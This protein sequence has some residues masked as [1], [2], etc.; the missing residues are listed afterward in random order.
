MYATI[1]GFF[2]VIGP[3]L[4]RKFKGPHFWEQ[5]ISQ[6]ETNESTDFETQF[7]SLPTVNVVS[8]PF[9][10]YSDND[11]KESP[12]GGDAKESLLGGSHE[13]QV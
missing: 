12:L 8:I 7:T 10:A 5:R 3:G 9:D 4:D 1:Y 2:A 13:K 6:D 11:T